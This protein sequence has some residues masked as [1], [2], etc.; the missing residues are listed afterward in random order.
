LTFATENQ[1]KRRKLLDA[2]KNLRLLPDENKRKKYFIKPDLTRQ[3]QESEKIL[4][5]ELK[6]KR[7]ENPGDTI[8][9]RHGK[10][11]HRKN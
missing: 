5:A 7:A 2:A 8:F 6:Q 11:F 1:D 3:Q 9:I 4:I 10:I